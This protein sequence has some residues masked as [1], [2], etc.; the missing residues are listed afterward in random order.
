[1]NPKIQV[2]VVDD[3][4]FVRESLCEV[5][6]AE[7]MRVQGADGARG[8][9]ELLALRRFDV[10][11]SDLR[12]S[13]GDG[14]HVLEESRRHTPPIPIVLVTGHGTVPDAVRAMKAGAYDFLQKPVDPD[15]LAVVVR[16]AAEHRALQ[17]EVQSLRDTVQGLQKTGALV[18]SSAAMMRVK[19]AIAQVARTD[20]TVLITGESGT[21]KELAADEIHRASG[22]SKGPLVRVNCAAIPED[23]FES[24]LFGHRRGSFI[25]AVDDRA[26]KFARAEGGTL[27]L[28]EIGALRP[29]M[30]S[31]LLRVLESGEF[32]RVGDAHT[33]VADARVIAITNEDLKARV[34]SGAFRADLYYRLDIFPIEMPALA[35]HKEDIPAIAAHLLATAQLRHGGEVAGQHGALAPATLE[36]LTSYDWPGNVRELRNV[37]ERAVIVAPGGA[38]DADLLRSILESAVPARP[39]SGALEFHLRSNLD[40]RERELVLGALERTK[41]KKKDASNLLGIDARNLGYYLRKH[42]IQDTSALGSDA[43]ES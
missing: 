41:N 43:A 32:Q 35:K 28:D 5:L 22:R 3:E 17:A 42:K 27:V 38:L 30:Q 12:M 33:Q 31:K 20:A 14:M 19:A 6:A 23:Q 16:R 26:G 40:A 25:G 11:V 29:G 9:A 37:I 7:G 34:K 24:E 2:L 18:G 39:K 10:I 21:G 1:M 15:E 36:V 4:S 13:D 8:A